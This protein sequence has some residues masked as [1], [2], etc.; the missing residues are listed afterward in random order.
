MA[1]RIFLDLE[2]CVG[3]RTC[4]AACWYTHHE[5][6][7]IFHED[8][9]EQAFLPLIC[10]HCEDAPC[11]AA[12]PTGSL[13]KVGEEGLVKRHSFLCV[14]CKSCVLACP[15]GTIKPETSCRV[16]SKCDLC[17]PRL[18]AGKRPACV[19]ACP[20]DALKFAE[21]EELEQQGYRQVESR[22]ITRSLWK[23]R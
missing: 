2:A 1:K 6:E 4:S 16:I 12:C 21:L 3:C 13:E 23:R 18:Q 20:A 17:P 19:T 5:T 22:Q 7:N 9:S 8:M 15:F 11:L 14:G 10:R